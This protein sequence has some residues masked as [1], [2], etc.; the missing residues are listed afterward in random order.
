MLSGPRRYVSE[1]AAELKKVA[2]P[3]RDTVVRLT[4]VVI[5]VSIIVGIYIFLIDSMFRTVLQQVL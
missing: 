2:W 1:S 3:T 4:I 5:T